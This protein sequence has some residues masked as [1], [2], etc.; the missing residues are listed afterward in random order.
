MFNFFLRNSG[1]WRHHSARL[2]CSSRRVASAYWVVA[3]AVLASAC[4]CEKPSLAGSTILLDLMG[5][6]G[7]VR[8]IQAKAMVSV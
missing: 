6:L 1:R 5:K 3:Q 8:F 2:I 4:F 7:S